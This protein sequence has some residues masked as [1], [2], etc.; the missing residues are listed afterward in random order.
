LARL[1]EYMVPAAY[2]RLERM[3]LT[4]NGKLDRKALPAPEAEAYT[5]R[6]YEAPRTAAE[7]AVAGIWAELLKRE[8]V[9]RQ[10]NFFEMGGHSLLAVA[11]IERMR[12]LGMPVDVRALFTNPTVA[13]LA[14]ARSGEEKRVA[15]PPNRIPHSSKGSTKSSKVTE[16]RI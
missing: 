10:D 15:V 14:A 12:R 7:E 6:G 16:I 3:P 11:V 4:G 2:V 1:P 5:Q 9:G 13:G 8:R